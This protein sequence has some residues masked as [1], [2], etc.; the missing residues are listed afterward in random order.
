MLKV[1]VKNAFSTNEKEELITLKMNQQTIHSLSELRTNFD[2]QELL[3]HY[4]SGNLLRWLKQHFYDVEAEAI[5]SADTTS[6]SIHK[7]CNILGIDYFSSTN[8]SEEEKAMWEERKRVVSALTDDTSILSNLWLVAMDQSELAMLLRKKERTIYLCKESFS[9]PIRIANVEYIGFGG[10]TLEHPFTKEQY[11]K[12]GITV[13]GFT[14][15]T[16]ENPTTKETAKAAAIA[17]GYDD[18]YEHHTALATYY[19]QKLK[20]EKIFTPHYLTNQTSLAGKFFK[21]KADCEKA[22]NSA[23][24]KA[25]SEAESYLTPK[26]ANSLSKE[27]AE[28]Y[29][30]V[31]TNAFESTLDYLKQLCDASQKP[32]T[33]HTICEKI[34][35][36]NANLL[37]LF[38]QEL[39]ENSDYYQL[40]DYDYFLEQADIEEHDYRISDDFIT[41]TL[42][43]LFT[44]SIEYTIP[45]LY[46]ALE[47][48]QNDLDKY[49]NTFFG[50]AQ[51]LYHTYISEI[52]ALLDTI[53]KELPDMELNEDLHSYVEKVIHTS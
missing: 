53:G 27:A 49:T 14:L 47:E 30:K 52:E 39:S 25:Y 46:L 13:S 10:A 3:A 33:Y 36:C 6:L 44:D 42:E 21:S 17:N 8:M 5:E 1:N 51:K 38:E 22:R 50:A 37:E 28:Y 16:E 4:Q 40:Y 26:T 41:R 48:I 18:F 23:I 7:L 12:A 31:I 20:G 29:S 35:N 34:S 9:I 24:K 2:A 19:H 45:D 32:N 15:P 11:E 43:T